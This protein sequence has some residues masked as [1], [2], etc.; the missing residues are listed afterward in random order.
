[1]AWLDRGRSCLELEHYKEALVNFNQVIRLSPYCH[2]GWQLRGSARHYLGDDNGAWADYNK[3]VELKSND[4]L[5]IAGQKIDGCTGTSKNTDSAFAFMQDT[6]W[7]YD[8]AYQ[9]ELE[10]KFDEAIKLF[11]KAIALKPDF[12]RAHYEKAYCKSMLQY[13]KEAI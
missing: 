13:L 10:S 12:Y 4:L 6:Y 3:S 7:Y 9:K 11:D 2:K 1:M 8:Q 5:T